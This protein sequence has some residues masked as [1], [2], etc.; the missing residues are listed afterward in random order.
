MSGTSL[1]AWAPCRLERDHGS[2]FKARPHR[3]CDYPAED[4]RRQE[5]FERGGSNGR[6][7]RV[8]GE[9]DGV[10][11]AQGGREGGRGEDRPPV[12]AMR[13]PD[14][15]RERRLAAEAR[16]GSTRG[17]ERSHTF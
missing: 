13:H 14:A 10:G 15:E 3:P 11:D 6:E 17:A 9:S 4:S 7:G 12:R 1:R 5:E 8:Q 2:L 16:L